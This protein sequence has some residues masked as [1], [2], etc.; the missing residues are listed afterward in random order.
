M[1]NKQNK[2]GFK[3]PERY[4]ESLNG[5]LIDAVSE[6]GARFPEREGFVA[7]DGYF[8]GLNE[9][10][11]KR[12]TPARPKV[13]A[14]YPYKKYMMVAA[15]VAV[16]A[17]LFVLL[18]PGEKST[19]G[20]ED[21]AGSEIATYMEFS[22][23]ELTNDEIAQLFPMEE[24]DL[25]DILESSLAEEQIMDYLDKSMEEFEELNFEIDE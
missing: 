23:L 15:A 6:Q 11:M 2:G 14:L 22:E 19:P 18:P 17:M 13:L 24:I 8:E 7:P 3:V 16:F 10:I 9:R 12:V 20:F 5:R 4:F 21:I 1:E 25:N